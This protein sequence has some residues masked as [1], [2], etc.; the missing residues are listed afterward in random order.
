VSICHKKHFITYYKDI[1]MNL[2]LA[3]PL[4]LVS[5]IVAHDLDFLNTNHEG[6]VLDF[7]K[8]NRKLEDDLTTDISSQCFS[9]LERMNDNLVQPTAIYTS[10]GLDYGTNATAVETYDTACNE[11][12][13]QTLTIDFVFGDECNSPVM[14]MLDVINY[15]QCLHQTYCTEGDVNA[16]ANWIREGYA[17][18]APSQPC[19]VSITVESDGGGGLE[20]D[21]FFGD[22][23]TDDALGDDFFGDERPDVPETCLNDMMQIFW[24]FDW[25]EE[26]DPAEYTGY[27]G[28]ITALEV[29]TVLCES[30]AGR[31]VLVSTD[32]NNI[33]CT[34]PVLSSS[35]VCVAASCNDDDAETT[36][37]FI[38]QSEDSSEDSADNDD[39]C[40]SVTASID[41]VSGGPSLKSSKSAK[42]SKSSKASKSVKG[43]KSSR[44]PLRKVV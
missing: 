40:G 3:L 1:N 4:L 41:D 30:E 17:N 39:G 19:G 5:P 43:S 24:N 18:N 22:D 32:N 13:G 27:T 33:K 6:I 23:I 2:H 21:D 25:K 16:Y 38:I 14:I 42:G 8:G 37:N 28:D 12:R 10:F 34:D 20:G 26:F 15:Y 36:I 9:T 7:L 44:S 35:P 11:R 31:V 29:F